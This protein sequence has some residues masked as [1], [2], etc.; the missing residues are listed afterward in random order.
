MVLRIECDGSRGWSCSSRSQSN[1][2]KN[3]LAR[4]GCLCGLGMDGNW[5]EEE[6]RKKKT[7]LYGKG[8]RGRKERM[9]NNQG[10]QDE[11]SRSKDPRKN[12]CSYHVYA[13]EE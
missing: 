3:K 6:E 7:D 12:N 9:L 4:E 1:N 13:T 5:D 8:G 10:N 2:L 11:S